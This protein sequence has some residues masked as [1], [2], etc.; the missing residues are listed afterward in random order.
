MAVGNNYAKVFY[1]I[2][3]CEEISWEYVKIKDQTTICARK[4][5]DIDLKK[6]KVKCRQGFWE[7]MS[8][9]VFFNCTQAHVYTTIAEDLL[10]RYLLSIYTHHMFCDK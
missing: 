4:L 7:F 1:R 3:P 6:S 8:D 10:E 2:Y 9:G 5:Q